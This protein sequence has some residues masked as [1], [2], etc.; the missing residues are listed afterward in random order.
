M[1]GSINTNKGVGKLRQF[2]KLIPKIP[3]N[4]QKNLK[5]IRKFPQWLV[6]WEF[7]KKGKRN[8][9]SKSFMCS[10]NQK[11]LEKI[12]KIIKKFPQWM[13]KWE[14]TKRGKIAYVSRIF[15]S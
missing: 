9:V 5:I 2:P 6:E 15:M 4:S 10:K 13:L 11:K 1:I 12:L 7:A 14:L 3:E 8:Y